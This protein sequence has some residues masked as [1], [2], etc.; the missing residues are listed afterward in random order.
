VRE[1]WL[2]QTPANF[3]KNCSDSHPWNHQGHQGAAFPYAPSLVLRQVG[4]GKS[5]P[6][7]RHPGGLGKKSAEEDQQFFREAQEHI[8]DLP[9]K[10]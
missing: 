5:L 8:P 2:Q 7:D 10:T 4:V 3:T 1:E 6:D 9:E